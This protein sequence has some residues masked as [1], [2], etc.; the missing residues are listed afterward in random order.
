ME[1]KLR[2]VDARPRHEGNDRRAHRRI[3]DHAVLCAVADR[4][5]RYNRGRQ[6]AEELVREVRL[7]HTSRYMGM[8]DSLPARMLAHMRNT[9]LFRQPGEALVAVSGGADSVALLDL[10]NDIANELRLSLVVAHVD[11]GIQSDSRTVERSVR[12]L[13]EKYG[14]P[15]ES[16][17][18]NLGPD[19][20]T[21]EARRARSAWLREVPKR[22]GAKYLVTAH[23]QDDQVETVQL[24]AL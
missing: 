10:L 5:D 8:T 20:T 11:H 19:T 2:V 3:G 16:V 1:V 6:I 17:E 13:A 12:E 23:H 9:R 24:L 21:T 22:P 14:L 15:F 18:L 4:R 7:E